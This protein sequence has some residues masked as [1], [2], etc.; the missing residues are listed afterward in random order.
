MTAI[1]FTITVPKLY[2]G[3][4]GFPKARRKNRIIKTVVIDVAK[5]ATLL[6]KLLHKRP[7]RALAKRLQIL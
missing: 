4:A 3:R 5:N 7:A 2:T 1:V 6:L